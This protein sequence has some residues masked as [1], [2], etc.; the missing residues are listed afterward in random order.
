VVSDSGSQPRAQART[1]VVP[2]NVDVA[3]PRESRQVGDDA[4]I[5]DLLTARV[6]DTEVQRS[7][8]RPLD[9]LK[10]A[11]KR[12][13]RVRGQPVV[14][15]GDIDPVGIH[16]DLISIT[17]ASDHGQHVNQEVLAVSVVDSLWLLRSLS[18][19]A[20]SH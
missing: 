19:A 7:A 13:E 5:R 15:Q 4:G 16:I 14:H 6:V 2:S 10:V 9:G 1:P 12:P 20:S 3:E 18:I 17:P 11:V 8:D